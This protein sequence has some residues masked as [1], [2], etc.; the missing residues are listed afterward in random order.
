MK[1]N[2]QRVVIIPGGSRG[3]GL[4]IAERFLAAGDRVIVCSRSL[5]PT[6]LPKKIGHVKTDVRSRMQVLNFIDGIHKTE[7]RVDVLVNCAGIS[8]WKRIADVDESFASDILDTSILGTLWGCASAAKH[9]RP[10]A[11]IVNVS[12]LA[13][14]RGSANNSVYCAAKFAVNGITQALAKELGPKGVRVNAVCPVY[15][16]TDYLLDVLE[17]EASPTGGQPVADYLK[18][19]A[20]TQTALGRLPKESEVADLVYYLASEQASAITGQCINIDCGTLPQ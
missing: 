10:G 11:A 15:V 5:R 14:K 19:F 2:K 18:T 16:L 4:A 7:G 1:K 8:K 13:G 20:K 9:M 6:Q 12:S 17:D 3:I